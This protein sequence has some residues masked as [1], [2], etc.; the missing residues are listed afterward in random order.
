[1]LN[2]I[3]RISGEDK[4]FGPLIVAMVPV[5]ALIAA[6]PLSAQEVPVPTPRPELAEPRAESA[7]PPAEE[8]G[9]TKPPSP[10]VYQT[11]CP[12]LRS[13]LVTGRI[14]PP[15]DDNDCLARSPVAVTA[16]GENGAYALRH[17]ALLSCAMAGTLARFAGLADATAQETFG[18]GLA[19]IDAGPGYQCRR[20]N[21]ETSGKLSEHAFANALDIV[22]FIL[23]DGR[24][25]TIAQHWPRAGEGQESV[26][27]AQRANDDAGRFMAKVHDEACTLFTTVLGPDS[28]AAHESHFHFDLGCHGRNCDYYICE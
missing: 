1:M 20:R 12:A 19:A 14:A 16:L 18:A 8:V 11:A 3:F 22:G 21:G 28:N 24:E 25:F 4:I 9:E 2:R 13:G 5:I 27:P 10:V 7:R 26:A 23:T 15:V 6:A 17:E